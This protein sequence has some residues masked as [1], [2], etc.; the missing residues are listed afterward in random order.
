MGCSV[1]EMYGELRK[2]YDGYHFS[3]RNCPD[4]YNPFSLLKS[5]QSKEIGEYW[6][7]T[8]TPLFLAKKVMSDGIVLSE[9]NNID[10]LQPQIENIPFD[11]NGNPIPLLYQSGYLT[12]K[13]YDKRTGI[14]TLGFPNLEVGKGFYDQLLKLYAPK[15]ENISAF[16]IQQ[17]IKDV[18]SGNV[19]SFMRRLQS[20]MAGINY[21]SFT[22]I[23]VEQHY[24]DVVYLLFKLLGYICHTEYRTATGRIDMV[25]ETRD[26]VYVFEFKLN[27]T[28]LEA[29]DQIDSKDYL[30][31]FQADGRK[32]FKIGAN[33]STEKRNLDEWIIE[34]AK[35]C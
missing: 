16:G 17:F 33:F 35:K 7:S 23:G 15:S 25:V 26:I 24:Q 28:A 20:M 2:N 29:L 31:P 10:V 30:L 6:Y 9:L 5:L 21:D 8:G 12:I 27:K 34:T 1:D 22:L 3:P 18:N 4:I 13:A 19:E 11:M 14:I 32:L